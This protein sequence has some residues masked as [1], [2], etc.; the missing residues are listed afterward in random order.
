MKKD[1]STSSK[2]WLNEHVNDGWVKQAHRDGYRSRAAYKLL[3]IQEKDQILAPSQ[4][5]LD[6][7]SAPGSWTQVAAKA[8]GGSGVVIATDLLEMK[9]VPGVKFLQGDFTD[10]KVR[11]ELSVMLEGRRAHV[12]LSDMAPNLSGN[13]IVDQG[14]AFLLVEL[15]LKMAEEWLVDGGSMAVKVFQ[16]QGYEE[17]LEMYQK[18]FEQVRT[19]KPAAS[20]DRSSE[21]FLVGKGFKSPR[22]RAYESVPD[23]TEAGPAGKGKE[24]KGKRKKMD[25]LMDGMYDDDY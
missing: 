23:S 1:S 17:C 21:V 11:G 8:V 4:L 3:Q 12:I 15:A 14:K 2:R 24:G 18:A 16:G 13:R 10:D 5:V 6:L 9:P 25:D 22:S 20:R 19:R 7:G